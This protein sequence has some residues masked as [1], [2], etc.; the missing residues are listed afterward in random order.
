MHY[1]MRHT[2]RHI[3]QLLVIVLLLAL[4]VA[5][6]FSASAD[7]WSEPAAFYSADT[8]VFTAATLD[9]DLVAQVNSLLAQLPLDLELFGLPTSAEELLYELSPRDSFDG[10]TYDETFAWVGDWIA[11][12]TADF[13]QD[14]SFANDSSTYYTVDVTDREAALTFV[15]EELDERMIISGD[16]VPFIEEE[17]DGGTL[18]YLDLSAVDSPTTAFFQNTYFLGDDYLI[19]RPSRIDPQSLLD[20]IAV[21]SS[22][23]ESERFT[24]AINRLP[25]DRYNAVAY[26][27]VAILA[28][29]PAIVEAADALAGSPADYDYPAIFRAL[30]AQSFGATILNDNSLVIDV[31]ANVADPQTLADQGI[32]L[33]GSPTLDLA[34]ADRLPAETPL[35]LH[36]TGLGTTVLAVLETLQQVGDFYDEQQAQGELDFDED[37]LQFLDAIPVS[38][39]LA[40][41]GLSGADLR[42]S[43]AWMTGDYA[44][45]VDLIAN[46][47]EG[48][49]LP[50]LPSFGIMIEAT[51]AAAAADYVQSAGQ[52]LYELGF[53]ITRDDQQVVVPFTDA[54]AQGDDRLDLIFTANADVFTA[55]TR[56]ATEAAL[57]A[58][59]GLTT[60][61][62]FAQASQ[63][64][65]D[66]PQFLAY[67]NLEPLTPLV[68]QLQS[69]AFGNDLMIIGMLAPV[70][71]TG[72]VTASYNEDG[73]G[74]A[75]FVLTLGTQE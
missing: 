65:I 56:P 55:G 62:S 51:D 69:G 2:T 37:G 60:T 73:S 47:N 63:L 72:S 42:E 18:I 25:A 39:E 58:D 50:V 59:G 20:L 28:D 35:V 67:I 26:W 7:D 5:P 68:E 38:L 44:L 53:T 71:E 41:Q 74:F 14:F 23:S 46:E 13:S 21:E 29:T 31:A 33:G 48:A 3:A 30:G 24:D 45:F 61:D 52:I 36:N 12:G 6:A 4:G 1:N 9:D 16:A 75:R 32:M 10:G 34:F 57:S 43:L 54:V 66:D 19:I 8:A 15:R 27:D 17:V 49:L 22:L 40:F 70:L 11:V 64:F